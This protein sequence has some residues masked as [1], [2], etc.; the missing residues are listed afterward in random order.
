[1]FPFWAAF[2]VV[3]E[4]RGRRRGLPPRRRILVALVAFFSALAVATPLLHVSKPDNRYFTRDFKKD[5]KEGRGAGAYTFL[6]YGPQELD[7]D[8][9]FKPPM[10]RKSVEAARYRDGELHWMGTDDSGRDV[11]TRLL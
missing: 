2:V 4:R 1:I 8:I 3:A 10:F 11:L 7:L 5:Q 6:P 9:V